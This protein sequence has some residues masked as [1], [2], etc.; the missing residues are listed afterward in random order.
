MPEIETE[1]VAHNLELHLRECKLRYEQFEEKLDR[2][3]AQQKSTSRHT[4]ELRQ[5]MAR[6]IGGVSAVSVVS[7]IC[8]ILYYLTHL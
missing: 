3:E 5:L 7:V 2:I 8:G 1:Q 4:F 6:F